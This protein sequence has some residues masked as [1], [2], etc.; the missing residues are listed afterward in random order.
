[1]KEQE[2]DQLYHLLR[3]CSNSPDEQERACMWGLCKHLFGG[4]DYLALVQYAAM[5]GEKHVLPRA[6][7]LLKT[8]EY[9]P[10]RI[11]DLGAGLGW[12]GRGLAN[13][14]GIKH[15]S[16]DKRGWVLIDHVIDIEH[17]SGLE[18]F[19]EL[20]VPGC[21]VTMCDV[22]HCL[23]K[24]TIMQLGDALSHHDSLVIEYSPRVKSH[25]ESFRLQTCR[26]GS[27]GYTVLR[28]LDL[29]CG[30]EQMVT[31]ETNAYTLYFVRA[32]PN[33]KERRPRY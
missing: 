3:V 10:S 24:R 7:E 32:L 23:D 8:L 4:S 14:F 19:K 16:V 12:L 11:I 29:F 27:N 15:V 33:D 9:I 1:M 25:M 5:Y 13:E 17:P 6:V 30:L 31:H 21:L 20:L 22:L 2:L 28:L 18:K 26:F